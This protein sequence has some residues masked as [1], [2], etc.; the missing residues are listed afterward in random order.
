MSPI[1]VVLIILAVIGVIGAAQAGSNALLENVIDL[2]RRSASPER[3]RRL[4]AFVTSL[5]PAEAIVAAQEAASNIDAVIQRREGQDLLLTVSY[6]PTGRIELKV[7]KDPAGS[8]VITIAP[9]KSPSDRDTLSRFRGGLLAAL[10]A[11][12]PT[13]RQA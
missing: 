5:P 8:T 12:D 7:E 10:R 3:W 2:V 1:L 13:A 9:G 11:R 6:G 4:P